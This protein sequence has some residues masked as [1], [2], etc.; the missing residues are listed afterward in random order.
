MKKMMMKKKNKNK[1]KN[2][3]NKKIIIKKN[4]KQMN[5]MA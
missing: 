4:F 1:N 5:K 2:K 3:K